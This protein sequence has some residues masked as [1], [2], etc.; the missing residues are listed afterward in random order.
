DRVIN[1]ARTNVVSFAQT[2]AAGD[3]FS[4]EVAISGGSPTVQL[5]RDTGGGPVAIGSPYTDT[6][7]SQLVTGVVGI[8]GSEFGNSMFGGPFEAGNVTIAAALPF[9]I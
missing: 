9:P 2:C 3:K 7:G 6:S 8:F 4:A 1:G 5:Y